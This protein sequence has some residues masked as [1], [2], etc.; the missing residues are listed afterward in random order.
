MKKKTRIKYVISPSFNYWSTREFE[1]TYPD[2][3]GAF[4]GSYMKSLYKD[5]FVFE[6]YMPF[7]NKAS[8][9]PVKWVRN[10]ASF[11]LHWY[12]KKYTDYRR[13]SKGLM[14]DCLKKGQPILLG[15]VINDSWFT[16]GR[17]GL[18]EDVSMN[19]GGHAVLQ[20]GRKIID[21]VQYAIIKNS[22]GRR[23]GD[24]GYC[25]VPWNHLKSN[26]FD[27]YTVNHK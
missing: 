5:G 17:D 10:N 22:W 9:K 4:I 24:K 8:Y 23:F 15:L 21:G 3:V 2:N 18:I 7:K 11:N 26:C 12:L 1:G 27:A 19:Q 14:L 16:V 25:Y 20:A 13:V 6:Y